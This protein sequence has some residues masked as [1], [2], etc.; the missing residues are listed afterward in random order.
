MS[1]LLSLYSTVTFA[2]I[3][4]RDSRC[5]LLSWSRE[6]RHELS[7]RLSR[8]GL[9]NTSR[10]IQRRSGSRLRRTRSKPSRGVTNIG[11]FSV[12]S[13][14]T[15]CA[16]ESKGCFRREWYALI[17]LSTPL[18]RVSPQL[19]E[20]RRSTRRQKK[21]EGRESERVEEERLRLTSHHRHR[22]AYVNQAYS[23]VGIYSEAFGASN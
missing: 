5:L 11:F 12:H 22:S 16:S 14:F 18:Y 6:T 2:H 17:G 19:S 3:Q 23:V 13:Q 15:F 21:K 7:R 20:K 10:S 4:S 8:N 9:L 1:L